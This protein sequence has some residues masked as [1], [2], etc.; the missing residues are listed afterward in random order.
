MPDIDRMA[1][2]D[3]NEEHSYSPCDYKGTCHVGANIE[4]SADEDRSV[5]EKDRDLD[6]CQG[7]TVADKLYVSNLLGDQQTVCTIEA[8]TFLPLVSSRRC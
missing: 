7:D 6:E 2:E 4:D 8:L 1:A 5:K 3:A